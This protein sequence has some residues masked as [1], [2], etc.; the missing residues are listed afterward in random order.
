L[1]LQLVQQFPLPSSAYFSL[2]TGT[3]HLQTL[4]KALRTVAFWAHSALTIP[5]LQFGIPQLHCWFNLSKVA[6]SCE[7]LA[8][9]ASGLQTTSSQEQ[10]SLQ[11]INGGIAGQASF[12]FDKSLH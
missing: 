3:P 6:V 5:G 12:F 11:F 7:H 8:E 2:H 4:F 1:L 9:L 10:T